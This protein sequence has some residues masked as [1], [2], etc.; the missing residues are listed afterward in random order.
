MTTPIVSIITAT[1]NHENYLQQC[2]D[3]VQQQTLTEWEMII[4]DDGSTDSTASIAEAAAK[5]DPRIKVVSQQNVG[6]FRLGETYNTG[7]KLSSGKYIAI[8]EGDDVWEPAKL[9]KQVKA[10]ELDPSLVLSWG[11]ANLV[12]GDLKTVYDTRPA[13]LE[14]HASLYR[15]DPPGVLL[16]LHRLRQIVPALTIVIRKDR[17]VE[18]GGFIQSHG[19]PLV[20]FTTVL[21][22]SLLGN[23]HF[24]STVLGKWRIYATQTTKKHTVVIHNGFKEFVAAHLTKIHSLSEATKRKI[25]NYYDR[26]CLVAY[27]R[28]GRYRLIRKEFAEARK[29][30]VKAVFYPV[31][32]EWLWR[33]RAL[34]GLLMSFLKLDVEW[35][36]RLMGR[37]TYSK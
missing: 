6:V 2:I 35:I 3:S 5:N 20:D 26:L 8:L 12:S 1:Y 22:L 16:E 30:Y 21:T 34:V 32:G 37:K 17:L 4:L 11:R 23:F 33:L 10:L 31:M 7:L 28:S 27:A 19:M 9:E 14:A 18:I 29:D 25:S 24:E 15:N 13:I 36:A